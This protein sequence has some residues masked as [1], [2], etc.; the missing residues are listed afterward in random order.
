[1]KINRWREKRAETIKCLGYNRH[2]GLYRAFHL[3][4]ETILYKV[5]IPPTT[6]Q[7]QKN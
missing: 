7:T 1:M 5:I 2:L 6:L 3:T 4:I